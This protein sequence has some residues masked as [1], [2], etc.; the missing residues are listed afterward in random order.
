MFD[1]EHLEEEVIPNQYITFNLAEDVYAIHI[2]HV[3]EIIGIQ[4]TT[5]IPDVPSYITGI[6]NLRG[7][8]IPVMDT[9]IKFRKAQ[10]EYD[11]LSSIIVVTINGLK[12]GLLVDRVK[13]VMEI[14]EEQIN[15]SPEGD[16]NFYS[17]FISGV[18]LIKDSIYL[19]L[20][21]NKI[22]SKNELEDV[23]NV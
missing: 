8:I 18:G 9:R 17:R 3:I 19:I 6:I 2:E 20:D 7:E 12:V 15:A 1:T 13:E 22:L 21:V 4:E 23:K 16:N 5:D 14:K 10:H 11:A